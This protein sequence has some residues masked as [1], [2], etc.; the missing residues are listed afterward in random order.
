MP[1]NMYTDS[2]AD[3]GSIVSAFQKVGVD[4]IEY[5]GA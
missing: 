4:A 1:S 5:H 2:I 3:I